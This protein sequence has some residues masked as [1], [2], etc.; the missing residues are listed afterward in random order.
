MALTAD[1]SVSGSVGDNVHS[2]VFTDASTGS[3]QYRKWLFGDGF[4]S[5]GNDLQLSHTYY[6]PGTYSVT[7]VVG[8]LTEQV[9][10]TKSDFIIVNNVKPVPSF[11]IMQ[12]FDKASG[13]YWK[14]YFDK[15]LKLYFENN[16]YVFSSKQPVLNIGKWTLVEFHPNTMKFYI[17]SYGINRREIAADLVYVSNNPTFPYTI[18]E[19]LPNSTM[20]IDE[21]RIVGREENL[22]DYFR[23]YRPKAAFL[24][25]M[26]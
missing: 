9:S 26:I 4:V 12:S 24:D 23:I 19:I 8:N 15:N 16:D 25:T 11:I 1:F 13:R 5:E 22:E 10:I 21:L 20:K 18:T 17:G 14:F 3:V 2:C 6:V 7:L